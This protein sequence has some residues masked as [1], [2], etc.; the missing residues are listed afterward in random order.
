MMAARQCISL[1]KLSSAR[2]LQVQTSSCVRQHINPSGSYL[3]VAKLSTSS[4]LLR[5][6][7]SNALNEKDPKLITLDE[8]SKTAEELAHDA[9]LKGLITV[10]GALDITSVSVSYYFGVWA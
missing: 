2:L 6:D 5:D 8:A 10:E 3:S 7:P 4:P 1:L 9:A